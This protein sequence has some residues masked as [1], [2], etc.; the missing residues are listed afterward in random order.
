MLN[1]AFSQLDRIGALRLRAFLPP[2]EISEIAS[3]FAAEGE[4]RA[5]ERLRVAALRRSAA[6]ARVTDL[7]GKYAGRK[8]RPVRAVAFDKCPGSN[9]FLSWHQDRTIEVKARKEVA[10]YGPWTCKQGLLHVSPP[11]SVI[12]RMT[13]VRLHV[14]A[15]DAQNAPLLIAPGSHRAGLVSTP[16]V[17]EAVNRFGVEQCLASPGDV[18]MYSTPILH[19][20]HRATG[21]RRRRVLQI[22]YADF[23]L[24]RGLEW[25]ADD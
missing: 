10:G 19:A 1:K 21:K 8:A 23:D 15:V 6:V 2:E 7:V 16:E 11:F 3:F 13:T 18:W 5:G 20:S 25:A 14:D 12:E 24:P 4:T 22:D 17:P 9:W